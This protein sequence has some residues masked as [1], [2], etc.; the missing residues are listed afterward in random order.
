MF[1]KTT[2]ILVSGPPRGGRGDLPQE[3]QGLG[4]LIIEDFEHFDCRKRSEI[5]F[6]VIEKGM[7][8]KSCAASLEGGLISQVCP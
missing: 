6:K 8:E 5:H 7:I 4:A 1:F 3:L 2:R